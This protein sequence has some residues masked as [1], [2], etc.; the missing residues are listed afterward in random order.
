MK[1]S[2]CAMFALLVATPV[3]ADPPGDPTRN[4]QMSNANRA[5]DNDGIG[6]LDDPQPP[7]G[8]CVKMMERAFNMAEPASPDRAYDARHEMELARTAFQT[9]DEFACQQHATHAFNDRS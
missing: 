8:A 3:L 9:G 2:A 4:I 5:S 7:L 6:S 1:L